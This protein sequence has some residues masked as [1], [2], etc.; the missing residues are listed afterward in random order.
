MNASARICAA[1]ALLYTLVSPAQAAPV[2]WGVNVDLPGVA[3]IT[4]TV[5]FDDAKVAGFF[6]GMNNP[7]DTHVDGAFRLTSAALGLSDEL[8][9]PFQFQP[10]YYADMGDGPHVDATFDFGPY[11]LYLD[12]ASEARLYA[13]STY[14]SGTW[15]FD[16]NYSAVPAPATLALTGLGLALLGAVRA[17]A[18][19]HHVG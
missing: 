9:S 19:G 11:S 1:L 5:S 2:T 3:T 7:A 14:A 6:D 16:R 12:N 8:F 10:Y 15:S 4:G 17:R 18:R 13:T